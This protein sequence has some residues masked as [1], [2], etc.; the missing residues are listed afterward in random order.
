MSSARGGE[1]RTV[2]VRSPRVLGVVSDPDPELLA[3]HVDW[4]RWYLTDE[5]DVGESAEQHDVVVELESSLRVLA[6]ERGWT[7]VYIGADQF[8]AWI[9]EE[10]LVRVSPDVYVIDVSPEPPSPASWQTWLPG[11]PPPRFAVEI[12]SE[13][14]GKDYEDNPPKYAMLGSRELVVF[15][16]DAAAAR[17]RSDV[18]VALQVWRRT[19]EGGFVRVYAGRGPARSQE[20]DAD[21][22]VTATGSSPRLRLS[23]PIEAT[24][25]PTEGELAARALARAEDERKR[26]D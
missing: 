1:S 22:V 19:P 8:F 11:V 16:P 3:P 13:D 12:V 24:L 23:R 18:R 15:D 5:E 25:V 17:V 10:P 14:W 21:L 20:I 7:G 4:S 26:A 9:R 2:L 6:R